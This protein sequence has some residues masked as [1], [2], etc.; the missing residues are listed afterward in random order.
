MPENIEVLA[1]TEYLGDGVY[2]STDGWHIIL[3]GNAGGNQ[4][5]IYL[6]PAVLEA[7]KK[8]VT[9]LEDIRRQK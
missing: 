8:Y 3:T 7:L 2:A 4:N 6:E 5:V 9:K 1:Q